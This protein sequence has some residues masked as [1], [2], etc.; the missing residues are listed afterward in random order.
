MRE[1]DAYDVIPP[2]F[3]DAKYA[4]WLATHLSDERIAAMEA[5]PPPDPAAVEGVVITEWTLP[6][7][8]ELPHDLVLG[9]DERVWITG[10]WR[11]E[12]W[13][14][15][16]ETGDIETFDVYEDR[17]KEVPAQTRALVFDDEGI[18]WMINGGQNAVVRL[19]PKTE[20]LET[21]DVGMYAHDIDLDSQ[22]RVWFND[23]FAEKER[24]GMLD[25]ATGKVQTFELPSSDLPKAKGKPLPYGMNIDGKDRLF[26]SQLAAN[27]LARYD[28][29]TGE[30]RLYEMPGS[31][32]GPRRMAIGRDGKIWI[33][34]YNTGRV[35]SFDP[36][37][38]AFD[39]I[40]L[41]VGTAGIYDAAV[42][43]KT[44]EL[45]LTGSLDTSLWH[46]DPETKAT[47]RIPLPT[48]PALSRHM[49]VDPASGDVWVAYSSLPSAKVEVARLERR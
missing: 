20:A 8:G 47:A 16:P 22:G 35:T 37:T 17:K 34:E 41:G 40:D 10:F 13:A 46:V 3:D 19:D 18:L 25:P 12:I 30:A 27:T 15:D 11:G 42:N 29:P 2:D 28:I 21:Y 9:P 24:I 36:E 6:H 1:M 14:L 33:P 5:P 26:S 38:E 49:A 23:Y 4:K 45:W 32:V 7:P 31:N 44:G 43:G 48:E 39:T